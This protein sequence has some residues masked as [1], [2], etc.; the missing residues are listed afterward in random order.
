MLDHT[1]SILE[2]SLKEITVATGTMLAKKKAAAAVAS[3]VDADSQPALT[4]DPR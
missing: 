3:S 4:C 2:L 1:H